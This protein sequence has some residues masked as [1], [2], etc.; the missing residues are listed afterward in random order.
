MVKQCLFFGFT[1]RLLSKQGQK[2]GKATKGQ[3][4]GA[5]AGGPREQEQPAPGTQIEAQS[6]WPSI[7]GLQAPGSSRS[8]GSN[9]K[10]IRGEVHSVSS[11][12]NKCVEKK[13]LNVN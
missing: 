13:L 8:L 12:S 7:L 5:G 6:P 3:R 1:D 11:A 4:A 9:R 2:P 10:I